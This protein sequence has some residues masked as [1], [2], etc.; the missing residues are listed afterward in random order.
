[1]ATTSPGETNEQ[2][3]LSKSIKGKGL[4]KAKKGKQKNTR[5]RINQIKAQPSS[6]ERLPSSAY[7]DPKLSLLPDT[8]P[9][10]KKFLFNARSRAGPNP[11]PATAESLLEQKRTNLAASLCEPYCSV[12]QMLLEP[13]ARLELTETESGRVP[14]QSAVWLPGPAHNTVSQLQL[15]ELTLQIHKK[16]KLWSSLLGAMSSTETKLRSKFQD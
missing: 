6:V 2:K 9:Y 11:A 4:G 14:A 16:E 7:R 8:N 13:E 12:C 5:K 15:C 10:S 1:M 3:R